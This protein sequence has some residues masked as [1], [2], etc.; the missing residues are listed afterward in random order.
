[1][2][3][4]LGLV[5]KSLPYFCKKKYRVE[6]IT[7]RVVRVFLKRVLEIQTMQ[8]YSEKIFALD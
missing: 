5:I 7:K 1:M 8:L 2:S 3:Y 6:K 4:M